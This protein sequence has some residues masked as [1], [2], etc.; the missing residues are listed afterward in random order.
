MRGR[1]GG[2]GELK[3]FISAFLLKIFK[4]LRDQLLSSS[5]NRQ[6]HTR[7]PEASNPRGDSGGCRRLLPSKYS[8]SKTAIFMPKIEYCSCFTALRLFSANSFFLRGSRLR[9]GKQVAQF[10]CP[11]S[12]VQPLLSRPS[13]MCL[14]LSLSTGSQSRC[15][16]LEGRWLGSLSNLTTEGGR[17][18]L[19]ML[20]QAW[21]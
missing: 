21:A 13:N 18:A 20:L 12:K 3:Y 5:T 19:G 11:E 4:E 15:V 9:W 7:R 16:E 17:G 14:L 8:R 6:G 1:G 10:Y 2:G